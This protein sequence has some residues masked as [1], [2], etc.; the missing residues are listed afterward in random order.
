MEVVGG[1]VGPERVGDE[2][3]GV[4][5]LPEQEV[6]DAVFAGGAD[7]QIGIGDAGGV[8]TGLELGL[9]DGIGREQAGG[10]VAGEAAGGIGEF[11][12]AAVV[13]GEAEHGAGAVRGGGGD[14]VKG[15]EH[16]G[17]QALAAAD[18]GETEIFA[19]EFF[20]LTFA[21]S[22]AEVHQGLDFLGGAFPVFER[23]GVEGDVL[24]A[25][26]AAG[27]NDGADGGGA[28]AM[29]E[30]AGQA[31]GAGPAPIAVHDE[32]DVAGDAG[33][34]D[35]WEVAVGVG[36]RG[37]G[38]GGAGM[39]GG[40]SGHG[41]ET[42][43]K[44]GRFAGARGVQ[45]KRRG[46]GVI[47]LCSVMARTRIKICG[48][49]DLDTALAAAEAG[50]DAVGFMF[51]KSSA[52]YVDPEDAAG[53]MLSLPPMVSTV[54]VFMNTPLEEFEDVEEVCPTIYTQLHGQEDETLVKECGPGVIKGLRF[55]P[56]ST[57]EELKRWN[58]VD[59]VDA[60][61][62]D[63]SAGGEGQTFDW[64]AL[65][66]MLKGIEKK[67]ILAGG[68]TVENVGEAIRAVRPWAV[69]VSSGVERA[70]GEK[71]AK[72]IEKF[73]AAVRAADAK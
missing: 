30:H 60:I 50:A 51:V 6:G 12:A 48:V 56:E 33:G 68:L 11:G 40:R 35:V 69:D 47:G 13:E 32:S 28:G 49:R 2:D 45:R 3:F 58:A 5:D 10:D 62:V 15:G 1:E 52:R 23:E 20:A 67:I 42:E 9:V 41:A 25:E 37:D 7:E 57:A 64:K 34:I 39:G 53:I 73:C 70:R 66:A 4:G 29:A 59:E 61:L 38:S 18:D 36:L 43:A 26:Q 17:G 22:D 65:K 24:D 72:L 19:G 54:G 27:P 16:G 21:V 8:E 55:L 44:G 31:M 63:G 46:T 71:D 14:G